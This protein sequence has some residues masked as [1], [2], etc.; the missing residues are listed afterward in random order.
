M[1]YWKLNMLL[2]QW[3]TAGLIFSQQNV[4]IRFKAARLRLLNCTTSVGFA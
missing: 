4:T 2:A 3:G 1:T